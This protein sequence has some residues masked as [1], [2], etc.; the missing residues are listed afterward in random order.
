M[1]RRRKK[2][3]LESGSDSF[4][5]IIA[6]IV[7]ILIILIVIAGVRVSQMPATP[8]TETAAIPADPVPATIVVEPPPKIEVALGAATELPSEELLP[9]EPPPL[10]VKVEPK[11]EPEPVQP[12]QPS[13]QLL[14]DI[15]QLQRDIDK[16]DRDVAEVTPQLAS[17]IASQDEIAEAAKAAR[18]ESEEVRTQL[19]R[20]KAELDAHKQDVADDMT[21]LAI[22]ADEIKTRDTQRPPVKEIIHKLT[23]VSQIVEGEEYHFRLENNRISY[24]PLKQLID[25][26]KTHL[27][28]RRALLS[29]TRTHQGFIGPIEGYR[30][31]YLVERK[32]LSMVDELK[33]GPGMFRVAVTAWQMQVTSEVEA[34]TAEEALRVGSRFVEVLKA[35]PPET[36]LTMWVYPDSFGLF[37]ELQTVVHANGFNVA[38]RPLPE[39]IPIAG[40]PDGSRSA[41]Q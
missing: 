15:T 28:H 21:H 11:P 9:P 23:P 41:G 35:A 27:G 29:R 39:G 14:A 7:G 24:V 22:L 13:P 1:S 31:R 20:L 30:M 5:D 18:Q 19:A 3:D 8:E 26:L 33:H 2:S 40:S 4:L 16:L 38:A 25:S 10:V 37:R 36:T 12:P 32:P 6:N 17:A 34:E